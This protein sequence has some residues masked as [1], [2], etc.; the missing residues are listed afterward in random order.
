MMFDSFQVCRLAYEIKM[1]QNVDVA[2]QYTSLDD[3][4]YYGG[5]NSHNR[6]AVLPHKPR[7]S[8]EIHLRPGDLVGIAGNHWNGL[9]KGHNE[10]TNQGG[11]FP[12]FKVRD[13]V[14]IT[15]FP[16]YAHVK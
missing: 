15:D 8:T 7:G 3:I 1:S 9:S 4:Y 6:E 13:K 5:Q 12:S 11:L 10:N 14:R 16:T 2:D